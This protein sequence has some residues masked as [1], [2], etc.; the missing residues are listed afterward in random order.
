MD[1]NKLSQAILQ[2]VEKGK[3]KAK[4]EQSIEVAVNFRDVDFNKPENRLNLDVALPHAPKGCK[5]M[6]FA[7]GQLALDAKAVCDAVVSSDGIDKY[8]K[9]K[10]LQKELLTYVLLASAQLMPVIGK[11]LGQFLGARGKLPRPVMP[12]MNLKDAVER[13]KRSVSIKTKGKYLPTVHVL[14][15]R[16]SLSAENLLDN[17]QAVMEAIEKKIPEHQIASV[18]VKTTMG[19]AVKV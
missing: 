3:G 9:D 15:G 5:S 1:R 19:P 16:E 14:I 4:F 12:G 18:Y 7:D 6:L 11:S 8:A 17:L 13:A 10:K 2:A